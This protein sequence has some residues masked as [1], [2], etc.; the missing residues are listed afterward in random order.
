MANQLNFKETKAKVGDLIRVYFG[1]GNYFE[2]MLMA[3][4]GSLENQSFTV[5]RIGAA[6]VGIERVFP[7]ASPLLQ[8]VEVK[9]TSKVKR[10]KLYYLR[11]L[12]KK[13]IK[14]LNK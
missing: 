2:G 14:K 5:R 8:K 12:T 1:E 4:R 13:E 3:I 6:G 7:V 11:T 9:K 10:A